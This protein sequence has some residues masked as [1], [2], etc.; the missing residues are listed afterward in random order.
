MRDCSKS[1]PRWVWQILLITI[2]HNILFQFPRHSSRVYK[3]NNYY[4]LNYKLLVTHLINVLIHLITLLFVHFLS[5]ITINNTWN[6]YPVLFNAKRFC[7]YWV[8]SFGMMRMRLYYKGNCNHSRVLQKSS[9]T[10]DTHNNT[11]SESCWFVW[12]IFPLEGSNTLIDISH[13]NSFS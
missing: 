10:H 12:Q 6:L 9:T 8:D 11:N 13:T 5:N 3:K 2:V 1:V 4:P 7:S